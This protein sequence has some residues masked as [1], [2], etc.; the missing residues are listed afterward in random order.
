MELNIFLN[1]VQEVGGV[2]SSFEEIIEVVLNYIVSLGNKEN[3]H[4]TVRREPV[5]KS[6]EIA[7]ADSLNY[8]RRSSRKAQCLK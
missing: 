8:R 3:Y 7:Q 6:C 2:W 1:C 4:C 5:S